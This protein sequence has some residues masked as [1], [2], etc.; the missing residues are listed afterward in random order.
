MVE[1]YYT[2]KKEILNMKDILLIID[3]SAIIKYRN[4]NNNS[5][6]THLILINLT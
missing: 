1:V 2:L 5:F 6:I 4:E 3:L